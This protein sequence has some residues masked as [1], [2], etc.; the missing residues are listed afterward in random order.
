MVEPMGEPSRTI[1]E[2]I[3]REPLYDNDRGILLGPVGGPFWATEPQEVY[4]AMGRNTQT[5]LHYC[6]FVLSCLTF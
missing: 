1:K 5:K 3:G 4:T 2:P 6:C